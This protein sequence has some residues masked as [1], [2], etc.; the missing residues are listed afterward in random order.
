MTNSTRKP[1]EGAVSTI[2]LNIDGKKIE[3]E[4]FDLIDEIVVE[5][6]LQLPDMATV[7]F[8]DLTGLLVD[9]EQFKPGVK[10]KVMAEVEEN[11]NTVFDGEIIEIE[12]RYTQATQQL[13]LR[14][15]DRLHRLARGTHTRSFQNV[16]DTDLVKKL[17]SEVGLKADV[18]S[19]S[20]IHPYVLQHNQTNLAFLR[21]RVA[22]LGL[23]LYA[24]G[25]TIHCKPLIG[26]QDVELTWGDNLTEFYPRLS[27]L[28]QT[29]KS[30][31]RS[32]DP[33]QKRAVVGQASTGKGKAKV[34]EGSSSE[35][36][37]QDAFDM[38]TPEVDSR[39]VIRDQALATAIAE[40][41]RNALAEQLLEARGST[42]GY[43]ALKAGCILHIKN[44]GKR[45]S[46]DYIASSVRHHYRNG[47]G[48]QTEFVVSGRQSDTLASLIRSVKDEQSALRAD[49][50]GLMIGIVTNNDDPDDLGRVKLKFPSLSDDDE[51]NWA[52]IVSPGGGAK[53]GTHVL[54]EVNDEVLVGFEQGDIH[55]P[56][57][58]GG[59]WNGQDSAPIPSSSAVK[60]GKVVT[61]VF[62]TRLGHTMT[63]TD[64][65]A[66]G[67]PEISL[68]SAGKN[69][70][71][72]TDDR[73][74][75][76]IKVK[77]PNNTEITVSD[78]PQAGI[79][80]K[81]RNGNKI[82]IDS[83]G[84]TIKIEAMARLELKAQGGITI[85]GGAGPVTIRGVMIN[86]N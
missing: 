40:S 32:W 45:F 49:V 61:R 63:Y 72:L 51:S 57:V 77:T 66:G 6:S 84:Q 4:L 11:E 24:D 68:R 71:T 23:A 9:D 81:D 54:P 2:Y 22:R 50:N 55:Y 74:S 25:S 8:R 47:V 15:F 64:P 10:I 56:Y 1:M 78:G 46:G 39:A 37:A 69:E 13:R 79:T 48:Y 7:T 3:R 60:N 26:E 44:V 59:L 30:T 27:S 17:A 18:T 31:V 52:R 36:I 70:I 67:T 29:S 19:S 14:A 85:D 41:H 16:S 62:K 73:T 76:S 53:R 58:F 43:P 75:P 12:P 42:A 21:S 33:Q 5:R 34:Q 65:E 83:T 28:S 35:R 38:D 82:H 86:L 80:L 20:V